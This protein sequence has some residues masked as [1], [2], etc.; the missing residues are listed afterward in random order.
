MLLYIH[1][2]EI[3]YLDVISMTLLMAQSYLPAELYEHAAWFSRTAMKATTEPNFFSLDRL[4]TNGAQE[5]D[6]CGG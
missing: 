1:V 3:E 4:S 6:C 2:Y 5:L